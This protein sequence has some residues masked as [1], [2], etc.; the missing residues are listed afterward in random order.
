[1]RL[2]WPQTAWPG[3]SAFPCS[4]FDTGWI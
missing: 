2:G 3:V 4:A 1:L